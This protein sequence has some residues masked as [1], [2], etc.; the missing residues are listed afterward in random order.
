MLSDSKVFTVNGQ[1]LRVS[2]HETTSAAQALTR[3][4]DFK[5][6]MASVRASE[7]LDDVRGY[8]IR[9]IATLCALECS[10]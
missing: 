1:Q 2:V 10:A 5:E 6:A 7:G 3:T 4:D 8:R 9:V